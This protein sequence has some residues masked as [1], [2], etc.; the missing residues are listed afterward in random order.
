MGRA[1]RLTA[2]FGAA[3]V[4]CAPAFA[5]TD[6]PAQLAFTW[7]ADGTVTGWFGELRGSH[8][9]TGVD[10]GILRSLEVRAAAP[11]L[12][13]AVGTPVGYDGYG[14]VVIVRSGGVE[15][16]YAHLASAR[17]RRGEWL[18]SGELLGVAGCTGWCTGTHLHFELRDRGR[19]ID[20]LELLG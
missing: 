11:G 19:L 1:L 14:N 3:L 8:V 2:A 10:I 13:T 12:V 5:K 20:P 7:P 9:H 17:V 18:A 15:A 6:G 4:F 16:L